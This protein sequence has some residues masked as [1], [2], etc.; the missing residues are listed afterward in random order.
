MFIQHNYHFIQ[1]SNG[2]R[3]KIPL[4]GEN[5][6]LSVGEISIIEDLSYYIIYLKMREKYV[7]TNCIELNIYFVFIT[8]IFLN[9]IQS[10][11]IRTFNSITFHTQPEMKS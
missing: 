5:L 4:I 7:G 10:K 3:K 11:L 9:Y 2:L 6:C 1:P 8:F